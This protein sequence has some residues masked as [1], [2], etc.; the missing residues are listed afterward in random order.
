MILTA[1]ITI[2]IKTKYKLTVIILVKMFY[3][4]NLSFLF[5]I[6][7]YK[8]EKGE[9]KII[10]LSPFLYDVMGPVHEKNSKK[11]ALQ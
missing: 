4:L 8:G 10:F 5:I 2:T 6:Y 1:M 7:I 9:Y 11:N 3:L